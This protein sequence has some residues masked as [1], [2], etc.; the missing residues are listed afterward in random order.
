M[1]SRYAEVE[2]RTPGGTIERRDVP[3]REAWALADTLKALFPNWLD[4]H[5]WESNGACTTVFKVPVEH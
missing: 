2:I 4:I 5:I 1:K 3:Y